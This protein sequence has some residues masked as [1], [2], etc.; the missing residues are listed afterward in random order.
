MNHNVTYFDFGLEHIPKEKKIFIGK[1]IVVTNICR[2]QA[3][4]SIICGYFCIGFI[5]FM[6]KGK[7]YQ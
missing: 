2:I 4:D 5:D 1:S 7:T 3:Y 6:L